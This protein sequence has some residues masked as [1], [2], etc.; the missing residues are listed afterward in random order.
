MV[1]FQPKTGDIFVADLEPLKGSR[2]RNGIY[3]VK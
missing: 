1:G 2:L 3:R